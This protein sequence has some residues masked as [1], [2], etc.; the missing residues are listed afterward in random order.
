[1]PEPFQRAD[2]CR[3]DQLCAR[4]AEPPQPL[5][6]HI[7]VLQSARTCEPGSHQRAVRRPSR[8]Q[9]SGV[10]R[11]LRSLRLQRGTVF[12]PIPL[13][14][15]HRGRQTEDGFA[16]QRT[17]SRGIKEGQAYRGV[18]ICAGVGGARKLV[19]A[20]NCLRMPFWLNTT[21]VRALQTVQYG[22][23]SPAEFRPSEGGSR[24]SGPL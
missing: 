22:S 11:I 1:M 21:R 9:M 7:T 6:P 3:N 16:F 19:T 4:P 5:V 14:P 8:N 24:G 17:R 12:L 10:L 23:Q 15:A 13:D 2:S 20:R 18:R